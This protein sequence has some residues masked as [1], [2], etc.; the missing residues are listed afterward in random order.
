VVTLDRRK[1]TAP[2][3]A[4]AAAFVAV[5]VI[6]VLTGHSAAKPAL[7]PSSRSAS[8]APH[9]TV[10][11]RRTTSSVHSTELTIQVAVAGVAMPAV[12][13]KVLE[14]DPAL[15]PAVPSRL[16]QASAGMKV[17]ESVPAGFTYQVCVQPAR[18]WTF[19]GPN[20]HVLAGWDCKKV[21]AGRQPQTVT[22]NLIPLSSTGTASP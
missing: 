14:N 15:T 9:S 19:T 5:L 2:V 1:V 22:F 6:G 8:P 3:L 11:S 16:I 10:T 21:A 13:V 18:G 12:A 17:T 4:Q 20:T 7:K